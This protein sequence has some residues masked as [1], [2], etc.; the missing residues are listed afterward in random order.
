MHRASPD[1]FRVAPNGHIFYSGAVLGMT[2]WIFL[3]GDV[4]EKVSQGHGGQNELF[5]TRVTKKLTEIAP[6][7]ARGVAREPAVSQAI[8]AENAGGF[9]S[10]R[11]QF[12]LLEDGRV[13]IGCSSTRASQRRAQVFSLLR[14][15]IFKNGNF[16][17]AGLSFSHSG[18]RRIFL[19]TAKKSIF[20]VTNGAN[21]CF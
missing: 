7:E 8:R 2:E 15:F 16:R 12:S 11:G 17:S 18:F 1:P 19:K 13:L 10:L 21:E 9:G 5:K 3:K 4:R 20:R 6:A 14:S